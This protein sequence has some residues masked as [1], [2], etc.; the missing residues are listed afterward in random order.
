MLVQVSGRAGRG[1]EQ[2]LCSNLAPF[3]PSIQFARKSDLQGFTEDE[4]KMRNL[5]TQFRHLIR[6]L[7]KS[8]SEASRVLFISLGKRIRS[9]Q[10]RGNYHQR[11]CTSTLEKIKGYFRYHFF[12]FINQFHLQLQN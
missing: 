8:R 9:L 2:G 6:H 4:L 10:P 5:V 1:L 12:Y 3:S 11:P 7:F